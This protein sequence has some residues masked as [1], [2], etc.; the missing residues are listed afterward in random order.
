MTGDERKAPYIPPMPQP[1]EGRLPFRERIRSAL[2]NGIGF[3]QPGGYSTGI[4][5]HKIPRLPGM[6]QTYAYSV[7]DPAIMREVLVE[8]A[9]DFPKSRLMYNMLAPLT[10]NS[11]FVSNGE[12]WRKQRAM[13][14]RA[15]EQARL[16]DVFPKMRDAADALVERLDAAAAKGGPVAVDAE[17]THVAADIIFRTI[18]SEPI[19]RETADDLFQTFEEFQTLAYAH[20]MLSLAR[21]PL[22]LMPGRLKA[23]RRARRIREA[24]AVLLDKRIAARAAGETVPEDDILATLIGSVDP[25]T[26]APVGREE[27]LNQI[28]MLFLAGH[29]TSAAALSWTLFLIAECP[30][31]QDRLRAEAVEVLADRAP[32]Y[33]DM[34][35]LRFTRD[36]F[37]E[38]L[39]LYPPVAIIA[40][41]TV[42]CEH[43]R[44]REIDP[45]SVLFVQ[46]WLLQRNREIWPEADAFDPDR[47]GCPY[48]REAQRQAYLPFSLGPRVCVGAAFA[49]QEAALVLAMLMRRYRFVPVPGQPPPEPAARL[50]L[51]S[52][53]GIR[54]RVTRV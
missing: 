53:N 42:Q 44:N 17:M 21:L 10:G 36:V 34:S 25:D 27:L 22:W 18:F 35:A 47:W 7:R 28:A 29:E 11:I 15:F 43:L 26:G 52:A 5:R 31:V 54:L 12:V 45:G 24:L 48:A 3:F 51:R 13:I 32:D 16:R 41:D 4:G 30:A 50:T 46:T 9:A 49:M 39:R 23:R 2:R 40:R 38:A 6:K 14:D 1:A 20:G 33:R 37:R 19:G 8:R